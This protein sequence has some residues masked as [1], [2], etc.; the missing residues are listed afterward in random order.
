MDFFS[1]GGKWYLGSIFIFILVCVWGGMRIN[2][3]K[4]EELRY[5]EFVPGYKKDWI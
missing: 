4:K 2:T 3:H 1:G 5:L